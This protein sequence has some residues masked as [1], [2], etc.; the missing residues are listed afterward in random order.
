MILMT[1]VLYFMG[2][3][4]GTGN[5]LWLF[6]FCHLPQMYSALPFSNLYLTVHLRLCCSIPHCLF[7]HLKYDNVC[8]W[9]YDGIIFC[10]VVSQYFCM[11]VH[12]FDAKA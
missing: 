8:I 4:A 7:A 3:V 10:L 11:V 9:H 2:T 1:L 5:S 6:C 12:L